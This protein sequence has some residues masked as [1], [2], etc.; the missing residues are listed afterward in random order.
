MT[1]FTF[2]FA[3]FVWARMLCVLPVT[4]LPKF[5][6]H[7]VHISRVEK[8]FMQKTSQCYRIGFAFVKAHVSTMIRKE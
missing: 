4:A 7:F 5:K 8:I 1:V 3:I 2:M 6:Q